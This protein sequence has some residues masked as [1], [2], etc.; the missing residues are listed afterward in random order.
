MASQSQPGVRERNATALLSALA[1][2]G[3][4]GATR[5]QLSEVLGLSAAA[6]SSLVQALERVIVTDSPRRARAGRAGPA[7]ETLHLN[8]AIGQVLGLEFGHAHLAAGLTDLHGNVLKSHR[9]PFATEQDSAGSLAWMVGMARKLVPDPA[10]LIGVGIGVSAPVSFPREE[11]SEYGLLRGELVPPAWQGM[12]PA[13]E[14]QQ[15][16]RW[17]LPFLVDNDANLDAL[18][19]QRWGAARGKSDVTFIKW[20]GGIGAGLIL[21]AELQRG[22]RGVAGEVG[23][24]RVHLD[25]HHRSDPPPLC[26][27]CGRH[28]LDSVASVP[29]MLRDAGLPIELSAAGLI[30][31]ARSGNGD[32]RAAINRGSLYLGTIL[33]M[34]LELLN[35]GTVLIG[36]DFPPETY[37][38]VSPGLLQGMRDYSVRPALYDVTLLP[39]GCTGDVTLL[40]A[41]A[42]VLD[43]FLVSYLLDHAHF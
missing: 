22:A 6:V 15:Q 13:K 37:D 24:V 42:Y 7:P 17:Q 43:S 11:G 40:G 4:D 23:H 39:G 26:P 3:R 29:A 18:A 20:T 25:E 12:S 27:R 38:L 31:A 28:C 36:G 30:A 1:T 33:A 19:E 21:G 41:F 16:L 10:L 14:L 5:P 32:A 8:G 2:A 35:P 9:E 34:C